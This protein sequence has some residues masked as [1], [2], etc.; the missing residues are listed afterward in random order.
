[1]VAWKKI[2][3]AVEKSFRKFCIRNTLDS[4][5]SD[6]FRANSDALLPSFAWQ[7]RRNWR[8]NA[9]LDTQTKMEV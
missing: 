7:H 8:L 9:R 2:G 3:E 5:E 1:L 4:K 6:I